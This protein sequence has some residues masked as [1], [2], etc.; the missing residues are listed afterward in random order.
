M[1]VDEQ[2]VPE[3]EQDKDFPQLLPLVT[4]GERIGHVS[5]Y[6]AGAGVYERRGHL[7]ASKVGEKLI[8]QDD[9]NQL[10]VVSVETAGLSGSP[11]VPFTGATVL[12]QVT[13]ISPRRVDCIIL[14][15]EG[16]PI[17]DTSNPYKGIIRLQDVRPFEI[18]QIDM[19]ECFRPTDIVKAK[20]VSLGDS[21]SF[22]LSTAEQDLGV[23]FAKSTS[24]HPLVALKWNEMECS[25]TK[26]REP[27]KVAKPS[28]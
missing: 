15:V 21:R 14:S 28:D 2:R 12:A 11:S 23:V 13:R 24:G 3:D 16:R 26:E 27:R 9:S 4:P 8:E 17:R 10:P 22:H 20:V 25:K 7:Y 1:E 6:R 19:L 18:D 5:A